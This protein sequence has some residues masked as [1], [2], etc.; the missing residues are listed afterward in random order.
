MNILLIHQYFIGKD[1]SGGGGVRFNEMVKVWN[2][3]GHNVTVLAGMI[4][5]ATGKKISQYKGKYIFKESYNNLLTVYRCHVSE[6]YDVNFFGRIWAYFS[7][8]FSSII[9]G[10]FLLRQKYDIIVASSP[11]LFLGITCYIL[12][13]LKNIPY[14]FEIRD[15]WPE[16]VI[17]T[18]ILTNKYLIR[19]SY[20]FEKFIYKNAKFI[21]VLTPAFKEVLISKKNISPS[22]ISIIPNAADL[23]IVKNVLND[24]DTN[25]FR[26]KHN[27]LD[28]T[29]IIYIGAHGIAN[30]LNLLIECAKLLENESVLFFISWCRCRKK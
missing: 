29:I 16:S 3:E 12:S 11:P 15:L 8:V 1:G 24:F 18:K 30:G 27:L 2:N 21:N 7:F 28:N 9:A 25:E 20:W 23:Q 6:A 22:K 26:K 4:H 10:I 17:D 14:V 13:K 19:L 5:Y